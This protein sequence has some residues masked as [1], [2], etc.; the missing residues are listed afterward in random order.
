ME[1]SRTE[2][3]LVNAAKLRVN[4]FPANW[5]KLYYS[6]EVD[7]LFVQTSKENIE[8][9]NHDFENDVVY[10]FN[11]AGEVVSFEVLDLFGV[12]VVG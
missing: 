1:K 4:K 7:S 8:T 6:D 3:E 5:I 11:R 9:S 12:F 10:N 2:T